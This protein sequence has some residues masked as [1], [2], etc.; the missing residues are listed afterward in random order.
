VMA[1]AIA[2]VALG[3]AFK[4]NGGAVTNVYTATS[5]ND[6]GINSFENGSK[7]VDV[8]DMSITINMPARLN[9]NAMFI[10]TF[11]TENSCSY[12]SADGGPGSCYVRVV[13]DGSPARPGPITFGAGNGNQE[14]QPLS[15]FQ[16]VIP[17]VRPGTHVIK[18]QYST[19]SEDGGHELY[20]YLGNRTLTLVRSNV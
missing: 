5:T 2:G 4:V 9:N 18:V 1:I 12:N 11:S 17:A 10:A 15:S 20:F 16:W 19:F 13:V 6:T 14:G 7:W 8:P 3:A